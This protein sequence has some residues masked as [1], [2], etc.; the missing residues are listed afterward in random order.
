MVAILIGMAVRNTV[1]LH[2]VFAQGIDFC[3]HR[4]LRL[5]IILMGIRLSFLAVVGDRRLRDSHCDGGR[6]DRH[7]GDLLCHPLARVVRKVGDPD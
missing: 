1:G 2:L 5:G 6:P 3:I 4:L 7:V